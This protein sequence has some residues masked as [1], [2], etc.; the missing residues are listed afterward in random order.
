[1]NTTA[2][3]QEKLRIVSER[4][5]EDLEV[6]GS[7]EEEREL[8]IDDCSKKL[9]DLQK[10]RTKRLRWDRLARVSD[11]VPASGSRGGGALSSARLLLIKERQ[12]VTDAKVGAYSAA[13]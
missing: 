10:C 13:L 12:N 4:K 6:L 11:G 3:V 2:T 8:Q 1:M 9:E 5:R 7:K